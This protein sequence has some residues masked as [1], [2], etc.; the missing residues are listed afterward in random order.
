MYQNKT[1]L[2]E[3]LRNESGVNE[4]NW[5]KKLIVLHFWLGAVFGP[6]AAFEPDNPA[7][8]TIL[9]RID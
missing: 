3:C 6:L 5:L 8:F 7:L 1:K 4:Y 2:S 9:V